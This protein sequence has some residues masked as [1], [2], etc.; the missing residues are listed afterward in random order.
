MFTLTHAMGHWT[1][2]NLMS[3][4]RGFAELQL[5]CDKQITLPRL[6]FSFKILHQEEGPPTLQRPRTTAVHR[7]DEGW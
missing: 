6:I 3:F 5:R 7:R 2:E 1:L 4:F